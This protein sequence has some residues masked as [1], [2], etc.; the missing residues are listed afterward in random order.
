VSIEH[1]QFWRLPARRR[2]IG[3]VPAYTL[4]DLR[5]PQTQAVIRA[6]LIAALAGRGLP[7][8]AWTPTASGGVENTTVDMVAGALAALVGAKMAGAVSG[9]FLDLAAGDLL[10]YLA[11]H[12]YQLDRN[13][14]TFTIQN[15]RLFSVPAASANSFDAGE[16]WVRASATGNR[17]VNVDPIDLPPGSTNGVDGRFQAEL[18]GASYS[19]PAGTIDTMV[20]APA[21]VSCVNIRPFDYLSARQS[22]SSAGTVTAFGND[23]DNIAVPIVGVVQV[24]ID[25]FGDIGGGQFSF[26]LDD[27]PWTSVTPIQTA[28]FAPG[29]SGDWRI[30]GARIRFA[31]GGAPPSFIQGSIFTLLRAD[32]ILQQGADVES[33]PSLRGRCRARWTSLSLVPT[34]GL[35]ALWAQQASPEVHKVV[36]DAD[37]QTPGGIIVTIASSAGPASGQ[38][39]VDV[40]DYISARLL[41]FKGVP[42]SA[43]AGSPEE[44]VLVR[45]AVGR[46]I[47]PAGVVTVARAKL[48]AT[49]QAADLAWLEYLRGLDLGG[50]VILAELEQAL[51]DAGAIT[52]SGITLNA[53]NQNV[54]LAAN[55]VAVPADGTSLTANLSWKPV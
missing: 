30:D 12:F 38:A 6:R 15:V 50:V 17:Y 41:G 31:N 27:G 7:T 35:I 28:F 33:D 53:V 9:R 51:L 54:K 24:R 20:T 13:L 10:T 2:I 55:E 42:A 32:A 45:S 37:P 16:L 1:G 49:Q 22:G 39:Q 48:A 23:A 5:T 26:K 44:T 8:A 21:G 29:P 46:Q 36:S 14:A 3:F 43:V 34:S 4:A 25:A 11:K 19:D 40:S 18:P 47:T 52:Y